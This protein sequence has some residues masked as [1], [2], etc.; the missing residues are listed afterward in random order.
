S[1]L[2]QSGLGAL[3]LMARDKIHP[4]W[5][6][7]FL[8]LLFLVSSIFAGLSLVIVEGSLTHKIFHHRVGSRLRLS[9]DDI[10]FGLGRIATAVMFV[11]LFMHVLVFVHGHRAAYLGTGWGAWYLLE[12]VGFTAVPAVLY[13]WGCM[14]LRMP[15]V[16]VAALLAMVGILLNR[17]N[18]S[19][20]AF[21]WYA[22]VRYVPT[23][24]EIVV[25]LGVLSAELWVYRWVVNRMPVLD[26]DMAHEDR[27]QMVPAVVRPAA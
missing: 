2:H 12:L 13:A 1:I 20:I 8:P 16:K 24:M 11:Y 3:Y 18:V 19:I 4:L 5:Y 25:T 21:K 22:P 26:F 6:N 15:V 10:V 27:P 9:N 23:W 7:E 17:L 14:R